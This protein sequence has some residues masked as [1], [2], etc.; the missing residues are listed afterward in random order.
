LNTLYKSDAITKRRSI[1]EAAVVEEIAAS[2]GYFSD[3]LTF[4]AEEMKAFLRI[5]QELQRLQETN[6][7]SWEWLKFWKRIGKKVVRSSEEGILYSYENLH[8]A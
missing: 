6:E 4:F 3:N 8:P 2:C 5:L 7:R 1:E